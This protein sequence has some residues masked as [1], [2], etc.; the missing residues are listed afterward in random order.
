MPH[1]LII[2][3]ALFLAAA[4]CARQSELS[5]HIAERFE[6]SGQTSINLAEA[7]PG[8][9][10]R[11][12]VLGP[13]SDN[14]AAKRTLGFEWDVERKTSIQTNEGISLLIFIQGN[15]VVQ[16]TEH[17]RTLGDFTNLSGRCFTKETAVFTHMANPTKGW[18]GL[19]PK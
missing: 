15:R 8:E 13:Y 18:P 7:V 1:R 6:S 11:V 17:P 10:E 14:E 5:S 3:V 19:F 16:Y 12:C 9:W 4:G 2:C